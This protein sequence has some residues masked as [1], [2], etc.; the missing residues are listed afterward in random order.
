MSKMCH[1]KYF[2]I[3]TLFPI[4]KCAK[5]IYFILLA[6]CSFN[7]QARR[8]KRLFQFPCKKHEQKCSRLHWMCMEYAWNT[9]KGKFRNFFQNMKV[10]FNWKPRMHSRRHWEMTGSSMSSTFLEQYQQTSICCCCSWTL[11]E[12]PEE[13]SNYLS[14][15]TV[16][17]WK[18]FSFRALGT[19]FLLFH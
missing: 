16:Q 11:G 10:G 8:W 4:W 13:T 12:G 7:P 14:C 19:H 18:T 1:G 5:R 17:L 9:R 15:W 6:S 2:F 3:F